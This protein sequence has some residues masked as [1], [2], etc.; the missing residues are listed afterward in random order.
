MEV[1]VS[2]MADSPYRPRTD[3]GNSAGREGNSRNPS[4]PGGRPYIACRDLFK[5]FKPADLEVV[6]LRGLDLDVQ[7]GE[8]MA[9]VGASGQWQDHPA[10]HTGRPGKT[11]GRAG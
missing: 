4:D 3:E 9:I 5:I 2:P 1:T 11:I 8:L 7:P 6:A 10:Q